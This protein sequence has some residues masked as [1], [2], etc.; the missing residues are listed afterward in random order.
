MITDKK[1]I[2]LFCALFCLWTLIFLVSQP[3]LWTVD[4][5]VQISDIIAKARGDGL[6]IEN[7]FSTFQSHDLRLATLLRV[8]DQGLVSQYPAG[9]AYLAWPFWE[10]GGIKA[11][12]F[13]NWLAS[14]GCLYFTYL[15]AKQI[16]DE[17]IARWSV[18]LLAGASFLLDYAIAVWPHA[19]SIALTLAAVYLFLRHTRRANIRDMALCGMLLG[20]ASTIRLDAIFVL[21]G[22][23]FWL[24]LFDI[25]PI[26]SMIALGIGL[27]PGFL[28]NAVI[29]LLKFGI[30]NPITY[31]YSASSGATGKGIYAL[32][33]LCLIAMLAGLVVL[34]K[35]PGLR[36]PK[37]LTILALIVILGAF[38]VPDLR[39][40]IMKFANGFH[41]LIFDMADHPEAGVRIGV[42]AETAQT[43]R[44]WGLYKQALGQSM[45]WLG[46]LPLAYGA[47][48]LA[49]KRQIAVLLFVL[50]AAAPYLLQDWHG[51][52]SSNQRYLLVLVPIF[53]IFGAFAL[54]DLRQRAALPKFVPEIL[55]IVA[56]VALFVF[57]TANAPQSTGLILQPISKWVFGGLL[58]LA[59]VTSVTQTPVIA[60]I[61]R[62][63][64]IVSIGFSVYSSVFLHTTLNL[65]LRS[66]RADIAENLP[67]LPPNTILLGSATA[68]PNAFERDDVLLS[69][70]FP[71]RQPD[72]DFLSRALS[73]GWTIATASERLR[74]E[75]QT[76][77]PDTTT[78]TP[79]ISSEN[80]PVT[81]TYDPVKKGE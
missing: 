59:I 31:G 11:V 50:T 38:V 41:H 39:A 10:L 9:F 45:P 12:I 23:I 30:F 16:S 78:Q 79:D 63:L 32:L 61:T 74:A 27:L 70:P 17:T 64:F 19:L 62:C 35:F 28:F 36:Q 40:L 20:V 80:W 26:K 14:L 47:T 42:E 71:G 46:I 67:D 34:R 1:T 75:L 6:L 4:E 49:D 68:F 55:A 57:G 24:I 2:V 7:G 52:K 81:Y 54:Q 51:G 22:L 15:I 13:L 33:F 43:T 72:Y 18:A 8:N 44:F 25:K 3:G 37:T 73:E 5:L 69:F 66:Q 60:L 76:R 77:F 29:N 48:R 65:N 58:A 21:P 56:F 53:C